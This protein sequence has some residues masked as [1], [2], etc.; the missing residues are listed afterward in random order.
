MGKIASKPYE[1]SVILKVP[2]GRPRF[3]EK[4]E[5][6]KLLSNCTKKFKANCFLAL[7]TG[8]RRGEILGLKWHDIDVKRNIIT[9][10]NT[11]NGD[12]REVPMNEHV[13]TALIGVRKHPDTR[14]YI[15]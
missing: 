8:M 6:I 13:K 5:I 15:L 12:K 10:L 4:E 14:L 9:L 11:K 3:L 7:F 1:V 2:Q